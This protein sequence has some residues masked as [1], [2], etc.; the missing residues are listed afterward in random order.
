MMILVEAVS[1]MM[2]LLSR[3]S[4]ELEEMQTSQLQ[5]IM[6]TPL[7]VPEP[8]IVT[9]IEGCAIIV[10]ITLIVLI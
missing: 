7:L 2:L 1:T 9:V 4:L 3:L 6:G 10:N 8:R 5:A